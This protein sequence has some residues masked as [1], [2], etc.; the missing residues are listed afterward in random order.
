MDL[1][2]HSIGISE[3]ADNIAKLLTRMCLKS[4]VC[5][6][7]RSVSVEVPPSRAGEI[8]TYVVPMALLWV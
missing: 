6:E 1:I 2:N 4:E 5:D 3:S 8:A 7:G